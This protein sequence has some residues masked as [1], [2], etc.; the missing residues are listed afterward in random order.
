MLNRKGHAIADIQRCGQMRIGR[1]AGGKHHGG[2]FHDLLGGDLLG[3]YYSDTFRN[4]DFFFISRKSR[5]DDSLDTV[6]EKTFLDVTGL[7]QFG[8]TKLKWHTALRSAFV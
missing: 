8:S 6:R 2:K 5:T 4:F 1:H 7:D 3:L